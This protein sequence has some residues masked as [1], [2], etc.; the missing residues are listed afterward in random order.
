[1]TEAVHVDMFSPTFLADPYPTYAELRHDAPVHRVSTPDGRHLWLVTRYN[2]VVAVFKDP[3]FAKDFR[4]A[5]TP[6][7]LAQ[8][9]HI[10][11]S[12][13]LVLRQMLASDPPDHTR[14]RT[15]VSKAF[16][17]RLIEQFRPRVQQIADGLLD[18]VQ[19]RG[20]MDLINDYAF[21]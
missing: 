17:P 21:L 4:N 13:Q 3:H 19:A 7:Q 16:T 18:A 5:M 6:D 2:D 11:Q 9:P 12:A 10:P 14:L 1:M 20:S 8:M 15:L